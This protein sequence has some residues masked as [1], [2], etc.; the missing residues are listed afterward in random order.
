MPIY[1]ITASL[2]GSWNWLL[3]S[4]DEW[5]E[6]NYNDFVNTLHGIRAE[7][8]PAMQRGIDF[9]ALAMDGGVPEISQKIKGGAFQVY[10]EKIIVVDGI[11]Y[12]LLGFMDALKAGV[13]SDT[14]R[15][16]RY[17]YGN[18]MDSMQHW[19]YFVLAP[20]AYRFDYLIGS[21]YSK[22]P[23]D[24]TVTLHEESY[25]NDGLAEERVKEA[26]RQLVSW[27]K[28][29]NLYEVYKKNYEIKE[30]TDE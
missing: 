1:K 5:R 25:Y 10:A 23:Y 20:K 16:N 21:G 19:C 27:L 8:T 28:A 26:T 30:K 15:N 11:K 29:Q 6:K 4:T 3:N 22:A 7:R 18:Y 24:A 2:F 9:E 17:E 12:K 13:I 14:K